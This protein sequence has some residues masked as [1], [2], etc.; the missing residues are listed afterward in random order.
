MKKRK[1]NVVRLTVTASLLAITIVLQ[2]IAGFIVIPVTNTSPALALIPIAVGAIIYGPSCGALLGLGW[3]LFILVSGQA[4]GYMAMN[5]IGTIITV[6]GKGTLA[7]L[8]SAYVY[9]LL[10]EKNYVVAIIVASIV[11]PLIN[12]LVYR[13]GLITFFQDYFLGKASSA[14]VHP[15][16][17]FMQAF[18]AGGFFLEVGISTVFSPVIVRICDICFAKLGIPV[19]SKT[20]TQKNNIE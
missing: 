11:T 12:S 18:I 7:G 14:G 5:F 19:E 6:V 8:G 9:K 3:S 2:A 10:K 16:T 4:S 20:K 1:Q 13:I 17:Y 15:V